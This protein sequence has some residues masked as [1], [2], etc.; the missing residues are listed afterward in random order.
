VLKQVKTAANRTRLFA[1][2]AD[3]ERGEMTR[4]CAG[5]LEFIVLAAES[6]ACTL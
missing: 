1:P 5:W 2:T 3:A 6:I 4:D